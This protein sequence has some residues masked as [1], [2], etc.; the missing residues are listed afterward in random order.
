MSGS[1]LFATMN[2]VEDK[3]VFLGGASGGV[4]ALISAHIANI[5]MNWSEME[6]NWVV[7][8]I[9]GVLVSFD[10]GWAL[11]QRYGVKAD[12]KTSYTAHIGGFLAGLLLG[13]I[14]L[15]NLRKTKWERIIWWIAVIVFALYVLVCAN[16][17]LIM[18]KPEKCNHY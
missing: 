8:L 3:C 7:A 11:Y 5:A 10:F 1:L 4:Y 6:F 9:F 16:V 2:H 15:R 12:T 18:P 13:I 17:I 14:L